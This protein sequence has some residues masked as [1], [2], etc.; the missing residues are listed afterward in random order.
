MAKK[1]NRQFCFGKK[2]TLLIC[3]G[4]ALVFVCLGQPLTAICA[5]RQ[6]ETGWAVPEYYPD[7]FDGTGRIG[8]IT[9]D[10]IVINDSLYRLSPNAEFA[11]PTRKH[12]LRAWFEVGNRVAYI[13]NTKHE[14]ISLWLIE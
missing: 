3:I 2:S 8:R 4:L 6:G 7:R 10:E 5:E 12:A 14:I 11:T 1:E 13:T 9:V